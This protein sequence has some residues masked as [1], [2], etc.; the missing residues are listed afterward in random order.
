MDFPDFEPASGQRFERDRKPKTCPV[1]GEAAI[2]TIVY[3]LLNEEGWAK[4][5]EK[6]NYVGG[7]CCVTYDDPKWRCTA[8]GTEIHRSSHRG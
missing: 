2:A 3:G 7:G 6:G 1:C 5:R 4:L 8:C